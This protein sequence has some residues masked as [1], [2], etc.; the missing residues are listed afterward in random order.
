[1]RNLNEVSSATRPPMR[2][3]PHTIRSISMDHTQSA[4]RVSSADPQE[5]HL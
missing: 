3:V 2:R 4:L 1:M 5:N